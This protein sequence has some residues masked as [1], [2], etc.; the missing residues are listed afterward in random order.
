[1]GEFALHN[2]ICRRTY[3]YLR[4]GSFDFR[5]LNVVVVVVVVVVAAVAD[6]VN[7]VAA[8]ADV[9]DVVAAVDVVAKMLL[10]KLCNRRGRFNGRQETVD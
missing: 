4:N 1:M 7:V 5:T 10:L 2:L 3:C 9:V 8:V 6:V